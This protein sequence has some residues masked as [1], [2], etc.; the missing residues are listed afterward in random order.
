MLFKTD[1]FSV[2]VFLHMLAIFICYSI[3]RQRGK[4]FSQC[5][6]PAW[7]LKWTCHSL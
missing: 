3:Y 6:V 2:L 5:T 7:Q 4:S 1:T